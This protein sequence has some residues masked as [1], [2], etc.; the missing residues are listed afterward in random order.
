LRIVFYDRTPVDYTAETPFYRALGGSE[1][2]LCYLAIELARLK[3]SVALV[4][5]TS[6][7]GR[8]LG[9]DCSNHHDAGTAALLNGADIVVASNEALGRLLKDQ[10][11]VA[12]PIVLWI[13]HAHD[14]PA[15]AGLESSRERKLWSGFAFVSRWQREQFVDKFWVP[16]DKSRVMRNAVSPS[17]ADLTPPEPWFGRGDAPVLFYTSTPYR[18]LD[19]LLDALPAIRAA[20]PDTGLRVFSGFAASYGTRLEDDPYRAL[21]ER[22][23]AT[24]GVDYV[25]PIAQPDLAR[26]ISHA[27][28]LAYPSTFAE[29]SCIAVLEAM[30]AG[31]TIVTTRLGALEETTNGFAKLIDYRSDR[32]RLAKDFAGATIESLNESRRDPAAALARHDA[33]IAYIRQN[34]TWPARALEWQSWLTEIASA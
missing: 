3:H 6:A 20:V 9:V 27:A 30:A 2:A 21:Y 31:A 28:A 10:Y 25:G 1:S 22:C 32:A 4:S 16:E 5:N 24:H 18:G 8:Y 13:Q 7:P 33:Q 15:V 26:E 23:T 19:V 12:R 29:T 34:Y 14:Q 11:R 17:F